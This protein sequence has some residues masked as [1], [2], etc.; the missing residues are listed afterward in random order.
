MNRTRDRDDDN[1]RV[2][3]RCRGRNQR[4]TSANSKIVVDPSSDTQICLTARPGGPTKVYTVDRVFGAGT[5]QRTLYEET[6]QPLVQDFISGLNCT[7]FAYGQT[8]T[9]KTYTMSGDC[10]DRHNARAGIIPRVLE[11]LFEHL[12]RQ[13]KDWSVSCQYVEIYNEELRDLLSEGESPK[14][15]RLLDDTIRKTVKIRGLEEVFTTNAENALKLVVRANSRRKA[16]AT[17]LNACSSRSHA[18]FTLK[19]STTT[20]NNEVVSSKIHLVDLA[21]S[22]NIG[23]SG[24]EKHRARE[25]GS[26]NQSLLVLGRVI[27][28]LV[29]R[30]QRI[31]YRDSK[32]TRILQDS[33]GGATKTCLIATLSPV[34]DDAEESLST[35]EYASRAKNIKNHPQVLPTVPK[36]SMLRELALVNESLRN[37][38]AAQR[39]HDNGVF[40]SKL[41]YEQLQSEAESKTQEVAETNSRMKIQAEEIARLEGLL[42]SSQVL[43]ADTRRQL[44]DITETVTALN[45]ENRD[46]SERSSTLISENTRLSERAYSLEDELLEQQRMHYSQQQIWDSFRAQILGSLSEHQQAVKSLEESLITRE[47]NLRKE[48]AALLHEIEQGVEA[49]E[50]PP[51]MSFDSGSE[52][53][54]SCRVDIARGIESIE[55]TLTMALQS[56]HANVKT[57]FDNARTPLNMAIGYVQELKRTLDLD[58]T[59]SRVVAQLAT[60]SKAFFVA[61]E[62]HLAFLREQERQRTKESTEA[63]NRIIESIR[64]AFA[65][66]RNSHLLE[67]VPDPTGL[68]HR[69]E[70]ITHTIGSANA[71]TEN[72]QLLE[73]ALSSAK[74]HLELPPI[75]TT[76]LPG[77]NS[78]VKS[79]STSVDEAISGLEQKARDAIETTQQSY[80]G[81]FEAA[82]SELS[83][84]QERIRSLAVPDDVH[85]TPRAHVDDSMRQ[86]QGIAENIRSCDGNYDGQGQPDDANRG[87]TVRVRPAASP[88]A[89]LRE[90]VNDDVIA[91]RKRRATKERPSSSCKKPLRNIY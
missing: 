63:E 7:V 90:I 13:N 21:G 3:V 9:G 62:Q 69:I 49:L 45:S 28:S 39:D 53:K 71:V 44:E 76:E 48:V 10:T 83:N 1:V 58:S 84:A 17:K 67:N 6:I 80:L 31:P 26:I 11:Q 54:R 74:Y 81:K 65:T 88:V 38:L 37:E 72:M 15:L 75:N 36:P 91:S 4:E 16:A 56:A 78:F 22:E 42:Q 40:L 29:D 70:T 79:M 64:S 5:D 32:L 46:L 77:V 14:P 34:D 82:Q 86:L 43:N 85:E 24:A 25:A 50:H 51:L 87:V 18:I 8:G 23:R 52:L 12:E 27:S 33:L 59:N 19:L 55:Q 20:R 30:S 73:R 60:E 2:V 66:H 61:Y 89:A 47:A 68:E 41:K 35:L 57:L